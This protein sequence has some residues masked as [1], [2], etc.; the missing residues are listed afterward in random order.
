MFL[1]AYGHGVQ[2]SEDKRIIL[3]QVR[4]SANSKLKL[5]LCPHTKQKALECLEVSSTHPCHQAEII[6]LIHV[7]GVL[8]TE[9]SRVSSRGGV[10]MK[11][12]REIR[13]GLKS[14]HVQPV[15]EALKCWFRNAGSI[16]S[17]VYENKVSLFD[18]HCTTLHLNRTACNL[19]M[20]LV[21]A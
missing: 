5:Y 1:D 9:K 20:F 11:T 3:G 4:L 21:C 17:A 7:S 2:F 14:T 18:C 16:K 15:L 10:D 6:D 19:M 13:I 8:P 12:C